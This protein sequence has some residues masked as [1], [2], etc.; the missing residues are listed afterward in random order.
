MKVRVRVQQTVEVDVVFER[1]AQDVDMEALEAR[2]RVVA[3]QEIISSRTY[4]DYTTET[5]IVPKQHPTQ[6]KVFL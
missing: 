6:T 3:Q 4:F 1:V 5:R 2:A